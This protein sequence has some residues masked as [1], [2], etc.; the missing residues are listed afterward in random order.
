M[1]FS[2]RIGHFAANTEIYLSEKDNGINVPDSKYVDIFFLDKRVCNIHLLKM[3]KRILL[4]G[5]RFILYRIYN[6]NKFFPGGVKHLIFNSSDDHD[7]FHVLDRSKPH[8]SFSKKE[9][10]EGEKKLLEMGIPKNSK[11]AII[12]VRDSKYLEVHYKSNKYADYSYHSYRDCDIDNYKVAAEFLESKGYYVIRMGTHVKKKFVTNSNKIIDYANI[13]KFKSPFMDM[14]IAYVCSLC[15][16]SGSG[17][18]AVPNF[19]FRKPMLFSNSTPI[20][21]SP[22]FIKQSI[23]VP[24]KYFSVQEKKYIPFNDMLTRGFGFFTLSSELSNNNIKVVENSSIEILEATK[25]L[26]DLMDNNKVKQTKEIITEKLLWEAIRKAAKKNLIENN[27][28]YQCFIKNSKIRKKILL[29]ELEKYNSIGNISHSF[30]QLNRE[31][32]SGL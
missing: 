26:L 32:F 31:L 6:L 29:Q 19:L 1:L 27:M 3:W 20:G 16:T 14:Y 13:E 30:I 25:E 21:I 2:S 23:T 18:D 8:L 11:I 12:C 9:I 7:L 22:S 15:I 17:Y 5:P 28:L 10:E 24:K 4:I